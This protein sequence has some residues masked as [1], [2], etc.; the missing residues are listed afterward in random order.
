MNHEVRCSS[1]IV[2]A[3]LLFMAGAAHSADHFPDRALEELR[4]HLPK[5]TVL[6]WKSGSINADAA[7][8]IGVIISTG[9]T[10]TESHLP[11]EALIVLY[12]GPKGSFRLVAQTTPWIPHE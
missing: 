4:R 2:V 10:P 1:S 8:D 3:V 7:K 9:E 11:T 6:E 5:A 12:G